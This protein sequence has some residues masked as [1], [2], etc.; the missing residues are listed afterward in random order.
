M[1]HTDQQQLTVA[2]VGSGVP[3]AQGD[4]GRLL[5]RAATRKLDLLTAAGRLGNEVVFNH[6]FI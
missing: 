4:N 6:S 3:R 5:I 1:I 2:G